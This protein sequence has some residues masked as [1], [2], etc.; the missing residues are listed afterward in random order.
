MRIS[1]LELIQ[2]FFEPFGRV[3]EPQSN[4]T[5]KNK[6]EGV[7]DFFVIL[8]E[9]SK[10]WQVGYFRYSGKILKI[11]EC[12]P[13]T[14]E[15]FIPQ[16]GEAILLLAINPEEEITA[17]KFDKPIVLNRG[18]WHGLI[19]L[20]EKAEMLIVENPDVT[21][22]FYELEKSISKKSLS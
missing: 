5:P 20:S 7:F 18:I 14:P 15:A 9:F 19:S 4:E 6:K 10:G 22:K 16:N 13:T 21:S 11:L 1:T 3:L 12:H 8:K 2:E 17:F